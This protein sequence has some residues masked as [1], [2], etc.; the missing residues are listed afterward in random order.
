LF[1]KL[2]QEIFDSGSA[3]QFAM[4]EDDA[5]SMLT[6]IQFFFFATKL[7]NLFHRINTAIFES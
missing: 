3:F 7:A 5:D 1:N 6:Q 2:R 4:G